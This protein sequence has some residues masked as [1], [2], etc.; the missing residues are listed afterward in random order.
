MPKF[1]IG[2]SYGLVGPDSRNLIEAES[3]EDAQ[4]EAWDFAIEQIESWAEP[5]DP[6]KHD[7]T[8]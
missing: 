1:I 8:F 2:R 6:E 7:G 3:L 4:K 5:Y